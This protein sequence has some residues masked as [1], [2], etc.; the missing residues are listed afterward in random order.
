MRPNVLDIKLGAGLHNEVL[1]KEM[2][3]RMP[4]PEGEGYNLP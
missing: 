3:D 2:K 4:D 1:W